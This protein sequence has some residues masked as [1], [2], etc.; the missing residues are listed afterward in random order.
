VTNETPM[1]TLTQAVLNALGPSAPDA[2]VR[3]HGKGITMSRDE[4]F[5]VG[6]MYEFAEWSIEHDVAV[7]EGR[8]ATSNPCASARV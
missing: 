1:A 4:K 6:G 8:A 3:A 7:T 2:D 5:T